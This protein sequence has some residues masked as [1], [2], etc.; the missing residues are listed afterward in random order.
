MEQR[1]IRDIG[2]TK[3]ICSIGV[4]LGIKEVASSVRDEERIRSGAFDVVSELLVGGL[5]FSINGCVFIPPN[6]YVF[7]VTRPFGDEYDPDPRRHITPPENW[8]DILDV[9]ILRERGVA[10]V[11]LCIR[12]QGLNESAD[13]PILANVKVV[14]LTAILILCWIPPPTAA[15]RKAGLYRLIKLVWLHYNIDTFQ[16]GLEESNGFLIIIVVMI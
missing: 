13:K 1:R 12:I 15:T 8:I 11:I 3:V 6:D 14:F 5:T 4:F 2:L 16:R 7:I 9:N 10:E